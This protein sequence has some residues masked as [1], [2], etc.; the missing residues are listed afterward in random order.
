[1]RTHTSC[2]RRPVSS[3]THLIVKTHSTSFIVI[4]TWHLSPQS[5]LAWLDSWSN[6]CHLRRVGDGVFVQRSDND[7]LYFLHSL[8]H[9]EHLQ[10]LILRQRLCCQL[11]HL[12]PAKCHAF[13]THTS[14]SIL[15][16]TPA[17]YL[18]VDDLSAAPLLW[19]PVFFI[20]LYMA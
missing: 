19:S 1:M 16:F 8:A 3:V 11:L 7:L 18:R 14:A 6:T 10:H 2:L 9:F 15:F 4:E 20:Q 13:I 5:Y 12:L 17:I